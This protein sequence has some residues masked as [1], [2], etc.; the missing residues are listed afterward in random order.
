VSKIAVKKMEDRAVAAFL[1]L[2]IGDALG[3]TVE[4]MTRSEIAAAYGVH[5]KIIGAAG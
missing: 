1:G 3:A 5:K 4:F 2:A